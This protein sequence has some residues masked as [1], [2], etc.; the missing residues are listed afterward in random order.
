MATKE[1]APE[2]EEKGGG[3]SKLIIIAVVVIAAAAAGWFF[4]LRGG[5]ADAATEEEPEPV[6]GAIL[7][8]DSITINL[9]S[10]HY[11]KLG[12]ALQEIK[13]AGAHEELDGAHAYDLA[14][15]LFSGK[16]V[17]EVSDA[18]S[19][20]HLRDELTKEVT[21]A[22]EGEVYKIYFTEFVWQ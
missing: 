18:E 16:T 13:G 15:S 20:E 11:L 3:K 19:R 9:A 14:I 4:F 17:D 7:T 12:M 10:G 21:E 8:L 2:T 22:Y 6:P 5:S 1:A